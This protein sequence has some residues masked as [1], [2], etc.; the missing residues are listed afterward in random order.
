MRQWL[1]RKGFLAKGQPGHH[2]IFEQSTKVPDVI[3]NQ[4]PFIKGMADAVQHGRVHGPYTVNGQKLP[5]FNALQRF[6]YGTP[7]WFKAFNVTIPGH[8]GTATGR[9]V[10]DEADAAQRQPA[11]VGR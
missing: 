2:W 9:A 1:G 4:P 8:L 7:D 11:R 3:K 5:Q 10:A 6:W